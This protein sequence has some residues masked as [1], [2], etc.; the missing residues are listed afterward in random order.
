MGLVVSEVNVKEELLKLINA[1]AAVTPSR[2]YVALYITMMPMDYPSTYDMFP[3]FLSTPE[4]R[5]SLGQI[6]GIA[7][8]ANVDVIRGGEQ[9]AYN[10]KNF[11]ERI[12]SFFENSGIRQKISALTGISDDT[13]PNPRKEWVEVR[14]KGIK[15]IP[16]QGCYAMRILRLILESLEPAEGW[17]SFSDL[18]RLLELTESDVR[19]IINLISKYRLIARDDRGGKEG[20]RLADDLNRYRESLRQIAAESAP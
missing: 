7:Y 9:F 14:L 6:I 12:F 15:S 18:V 3:E 19:K 2:N 8:A 10:F 1:L 16:E 20:Y 5:E 4:L 13:I 11:L 17:R